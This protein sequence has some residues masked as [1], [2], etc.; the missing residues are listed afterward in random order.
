MQN[1]AAYAL[2]GR[3]YVERALACVRPPTPPTQSPAG[4]WDP[5][6]VVVGGV[7]LDLTCGMGFPP[8]AHRHNGEDLMRVSNAAVGGELGHCPAACSLPKAQNVCGGAGV[9]ILAERAPRLSPQSRT[10]S[11]L[12]KLRPCPSYSRRRDLINLGPDFDSVPNIVQPHKTWV[13]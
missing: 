10:P 11:P 3:A 5:T 6:F 8:L 4:C 13:W 9:R 1:I 7:K 12:Y 2:P